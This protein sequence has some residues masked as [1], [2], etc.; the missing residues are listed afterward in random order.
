MPRNE[1]IAVGGVTLSGL[2]ATALLVVAC[3]TGTSPTT[4]PQ[5]PTSTSGEISLTTMTSAVATTT[6]T[7]QSLLSLSGTIAWIGDTTEVWRIWKVEPVTGE[8][9]PFSDIALFGSPAFE[10]SPD[11]RWAATLDPLLHV[12]VLDSSGEVAFR[13]SAEA[14]FWLD[15]SAGGEWLTYRSDDAMVVLDTTTGEEWHPIQDPGAGHWAPTGSL[16]WVD[17]SGSGPIIVDAETETVTPVSSVERV[18]Q[19]A[20]SA[21]G[22]RLVVSQPEFEAGTALMLVA[23]DGR[24]TEVDRVEGGVTRISWS[25]DDSVVAYTVEGEDEAFT[26]LLDVESG[27]Q[28]A[29]IDAAGALDWSNEGLAIVEV[30][31]SVLVTNDG[32][33]VRRSSFVPLDG[34]EETVFSGTYFAR[35]GRSG[36]LVG[37]VGT[38]PRLYADADVPLDPSW[39]P[40][41]LDDGTRLVFVASLD[42]NRNK[43]LY[44][45]DDAGMAPL[46]DYVG[47]DL[48]PALLGEDIVFLS[49]RGGERQINVRDLATGDTQTLPD[50]GLPAEVVALSPHLDRLAILGVDGWSTSVFEVDLDSGKAVE[51]LGVA[52]PV[53]VL[54]DGETPPPEAGVGASGAPVWSPRAD[55]FAVPTNAG[56]AAISPAD[57]FALGADIESMNAD[58]Q[59]MMAENGFDDLEPHNLLPQCFYSTSWSPDGE[60]LAFV[61]PCLSLWPVGLWAVDEIGNEPR[62]LASPLMSVSGVAWSPDGEEIAFS[63]ADLQTQLEAVS[64]VPADGGTEETVA[65]GGVLPAWSPDGTRLA[66]VVMSDRD[67]TLVVREPDGTL[68]EVV[69]VEGPTRPMPPVWSPDGEHLAYFSSVDPGIYVIE[70]RQGASP[71]RIIEGAVAGFDWR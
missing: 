54:P 22:D 32:D 4:T 51:V 5:P 21:R 47:D 31:E 14:T 2:V 58:Y 29:D 71:H 12:I 59:E 1:S 40:V 7:A 6:M 28:I 24:A 26:R 39:E 36:I 42:G 48:D 37:E 46:T 44:L 35:F 63:H 53:I 61:Y 15:W 9:R 56:A 45:L 19:Y 69:T 11:G 13:S 70:A 57:G 33:I 8:T 20:W 16:L 62:L 66:F 43:E 67:A 3:T 60:S 52:D 23:A 49:D 10:V 64:V 17:V 25:D 41:F 55:G 50:T 27:R 65:Q 34:S 18:G 68:T 30:D 38:E